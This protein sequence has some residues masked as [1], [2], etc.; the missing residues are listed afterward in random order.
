MLGLA[1]IGKAILSFFTGG[2][3][4]GIAAELEDA[5]EARLKAETDTDK[6]VADQRIAQIQA[7]ASVQRAEAGSPINAF[8]RACIA[9]PVAILLAK[10]LV[11]D[12]ALGQW[13][14]GTT[15]ALSPEL[16]SVVTAVV[17]FYFLYET[18]ALFG[19]RK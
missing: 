16:W 1:G 19:R 6:L 7:R 11:Y 15:D 9:L 4:K 12:K 3:L 8:I 14:G 17:G 5:Y 10:V 2:G 18:V 13:T